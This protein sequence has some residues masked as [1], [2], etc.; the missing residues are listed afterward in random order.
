LLAKLAKMRSLGAFK[1]GVG[2]AEAGIHDA[3]FEPEQPM[4]MVGALNALTMAAGNQVAG[5]RLG[6]YVSKNMELE[7]YLGLASM[8]HLSFIL[9]AAAEGGVA[10]SFWNGLLEGWA[11]RMKKMDAGFLAAS[12]GGK[13][14][15]AVKAGLG[16]EGL[17]KLAD[18]ARDWTRGGV[19]SA[20]LVWMAPVVAGEEQA[21]PSAR[22]AKLIVWGATVG[23]VFG[24]GFKVGDLHLDTESKRWLCESAL[25]GARVRL[26][27]LADV[28]ALRSHLADALTGVVAQERKSA[29]ARPM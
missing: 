21:D 24:P 23:E 14:I 5:R 28:D 17:A 29:P 4:G 19:D 15:G 26:G 12:F 1:P 2:E 20:K 13:D 7:P 10:G 9:G 25:A 11:P 8:E 22:A 6:F 18:L 27:A 16:E 3:D